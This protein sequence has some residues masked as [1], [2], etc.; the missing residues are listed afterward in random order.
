MRKPGSSE[1]RCS[2]VATHLQLSHIMRKPEFCI[3]E[4]KDQQISF[5]VTVKLIST[6]V[7]AT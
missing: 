6:S 5:A 1:D 2:G 7:F 4:N 3:C